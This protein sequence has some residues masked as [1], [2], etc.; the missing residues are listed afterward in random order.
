MLS[1]WNNLI[2]SKRSYSP[3]AFFTWF[4][5]YQTTRIRSANFPECSPVALLHFMDILR[6]GYT[7]QST[8]KQTNKK[9][10]I[11]KSINVKLPDIVKDVNDV[12]SALQVNMAVDSLIPSS[13][14]SNDEEQSYSSNFLKG[15][16]DQNKNRCALHKLSTA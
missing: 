6:Y 4:A 5:L 12:A 10:V 7:T 2:S 16:V 15:E 13:K 14:S 9:T 11:E 1:Q 8:N 3:V